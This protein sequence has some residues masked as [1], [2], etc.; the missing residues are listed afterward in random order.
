MSISG[1]IEIRLLASR[2]Y[3]MP[4]WTNSNP[5]PQAMIAD[6]QRLRNALRGIQAAAREESRSTS[7]WPAGKGLAAVGRP[8]RGPAES[9]PETD[10][11]PG[12]A[13]LGP[14][15]GHRRGHSR[16][17]GGD[18]LRRDR[19]G[20]VDPVAE[21]LPGDGPRRRRPDRPYPA[22]THRRAERGRTD[23]RRNRLAPGPRRGLQGPLLRVD[24]AKQLHQADD[25]RH[26]A[27]RDAERSATSTST[28]RSFSTRPTNGR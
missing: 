7:G 26:P 1:T 22:A 11:R 15:G 28:T 6:R 10:L 8:L 9:G 2:H 24:R 20:Q 14:A 23:R 19:L 12:P 21:D 5:D 25:R 13:D 3:S 16:P 27:G 4:R 18:R 17:P